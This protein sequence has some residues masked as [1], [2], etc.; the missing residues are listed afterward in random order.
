MLE[1]ECGVAS[2]KRA[3]INVRQWHGGFQCHP[4]ARAHI[5]AALP[6]HHYDGV[7]GMALM[8]RT[9]VYARI[10]PQFGP[11]YQ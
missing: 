3:S 2:H 11:T 7:G 6:H 1:D 5:V 4:L 8:T 10:G 9:T